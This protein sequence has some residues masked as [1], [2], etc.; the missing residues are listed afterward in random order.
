MGKKHKCPAFE[1][2]ERWLVSFADM[3]TLLFALF[4]VLFAL[5]D[6]SDAPEIDQAAGAIQESFN[7][8]LEDIPVERRVGPTESGFGIFEHM[9]GDSVR[10]P[11]SPKFPSGQKNIAVIATDKNK[12][13]IE[14][15]NRLYGPNKVPDATEEGQ[16]RIVSVHR[17]SDGIRLRLLASHFYDAGSYTVKAQAKR[18]LAE[19]SKVLKEFGKRVT[20]E[21]H[22]DSMPASGKLTNWELSSMRASNIVRYLINAHDFPPSMISAAGYADTKPI[23]HNGTEAGRRLNRR[24]EIRLH[25]DD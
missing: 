12:I 20:I 6:G 4:V 14:L 24:I 8:V 15:E 3:M 9:R 17:D 2:H 5:K 16:E 7:A 10:E 19:I 25:Y 22:T 13:E 23:A 18:E 1:N 11:L 21:G